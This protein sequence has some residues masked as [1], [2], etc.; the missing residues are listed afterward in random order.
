MIEGIYRDRIRDGSGRLAFDSGWSCNTIVDTAWP[1]LAGLLRG[2][3]R[4]GGVRF[5]AVGA[6]RPEWDGEKRVTVSPASDRLEDEVD[7]LRIEREQIVYLDARGQETLKPTPRIEVRASLSW[8]DENRTLREFGLFGGNATKSRNSGYLIN[9]VVHPRID[10]EAGATLTRHLRL[11]FQAGPGHVP[12]PRPFH[13]LESLPIKIIDG[14]GDTYAAAL[15]GA[16]VETVGNLADSDPAVLDVDLPPGKVIELRARARLALQVAAA[17]SAAEGLLEE[18]VGDVLA[19]RASELALDTGVSEE[20]VLNL[21]EQ[22][23]ILQLALD[24]KFIRRLLVRELVR[25]AEGAPGEGRLE[26]EVIYTR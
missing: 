25:A 22:V 13:W 5:L 24:H 23:S 2:E 17:L 14:V 12:G 26:T 11:S 19:A 16:G 9:H 8:P 21:Q 7:R 15:A 18:K 6:G 10:L 3:R 1:L 20:E 4:M